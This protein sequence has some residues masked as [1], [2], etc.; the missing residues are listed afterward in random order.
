MQKDLPDPLRGL[1]GVDAHVETAGI[2]DTVHAAQRRRALLCQDRHRLPLADLRAES[3]SDPSRLR[4][5]LF[6]C[7]A[8]RSVIYGGTA[9]IF[10]FCKFKSVKNCFQKLITPFILIK[11]IYVKSQ[12]YLTKP[13]LIYLKLKMPFLQYSPAKS[14][15]KTFLIKKTSKENV[16]YKNSPVT[17]QIAPSALY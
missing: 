6:I 5:E 11:Y 17:R 10:L 12:K 7:K 13:Y 8:Y 14:S 9:P 3:T 1:L 15:Q 2:N 4:S 16:L